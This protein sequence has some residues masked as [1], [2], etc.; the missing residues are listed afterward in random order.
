ASH[1][2]EVPDHEEAIS[3]LSNAEN[4]YV[5]TFSK[6]LTFDHSA[7]TLDN[8]D[9]VIDSVHLLLSFHFSDTF[10]FSFFLRG[11]PLA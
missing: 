2:V 11:P 6:N 4:C 7:I 3:H 5:C 8:S 10:N 9:V 1:H